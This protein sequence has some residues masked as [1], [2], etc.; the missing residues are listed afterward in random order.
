MPGLAVILSGGKTGLQPDAI[1]RMAEA[2][3]HE[4]FQVIGTYSEDAAGV[5]IG[6]ACDIESYGGKMPY[7][8]K[9][10]D[11][12]L[13]FFGEHHSDERGAQDASEV[14]DL[15]ERHGKQFLRYLN[16]WFQG[17]LI[18]RRINELLVFNDRYGM[19]RVYRHEENGTLLLATEAKAI[20]RVRPHLR[21]LDLQA[22]GEMIACGGV[23]DH[24]SL[25]KG[26]TTLPGASLLRF[27]N[28]H[29]F[30]ADNYFRREEWEGQ[31]VLSGPE[32]EEAAVAVF[33]KIVRR[34]WRSSQP[35]AVSLTGGLDSRLIMAYL[36][37][38]AQAPNCYTFDGLYKES[39]DVKIARKVAKICGC[40]H[41]VLALDR[42]FL[43]S[44]APLAERTVYISD[45]TLEA[46]SAYEL[47]LNG[48][49]RA[50]AKVRLTGSLGSEVIRG[51]RAFKAVMPQ[52]ASLHPEM[53][54]HVRQ[55]VETFNRNSVGHDLSFSVFKQ[56]PWQYSNRLAV[57]QSQ[58]TVR[59]PFMDNELVSLMYCAPISHRPS[60]HLSQKLIGAGNPQLLELPTDTGNSSWLY[61]KVN[62]FLFKA[63]YCYK[64]GMPNWMEKLH[65]YARPLPLEKYLR[66]LHRFAHPRIWFRHELSSYVKSILLD[67]RTLSRDFLQRKVVEEMVTR[68][69]RGT[70]NY[71]DDIERLLTLELTCRLFID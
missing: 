25:F 64:G 27:Q 48:K 55:G 5:S 68:H 17:V 7:W 13:F 49:A 53:T 6:W 9:R 59:T 34:Y 32:F 10:R 63:D 50:L 18:D 35:L 41:K 67:H 69:I 71:T 15:Y 58:L 47:Y 61:R 31:S 1:Q 29:L 62:D 60:Q 54:A 36:R 4:L 65:Y 46:T 51:V 23:L 16:G 20:L 3:Q 26:I 21:M 45:G 2:M 42:S 30:S 14:V 24:R 37:E 22:L 19:Q 39:I 66:G 57:E 70:H 40:P 12:V 28:G 11:I 33:P 38:E 43:G 56:A 52:T 44:F 8:N